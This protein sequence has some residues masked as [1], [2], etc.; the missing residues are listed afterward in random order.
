MFWDSKV[1]TATMVL[2][3]IFVSLREN[4]LVSARPQ[5]GGGKNFKSLTPRS[6]ER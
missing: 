5:D 3:I 4:D 1:R 2:A 6:Q